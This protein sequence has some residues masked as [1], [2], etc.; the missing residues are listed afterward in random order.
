MNVKAGGQKNAGWF[1]G[2]MTKCVVESASF[3]I[4]TLNPDSSKNSL[5]QTEKVLVNV[6]TD[7]VGTGRATRETVEQT[8]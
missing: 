1:L 6:V 8:D 3:A 5:V 2:G 7:P 4:N